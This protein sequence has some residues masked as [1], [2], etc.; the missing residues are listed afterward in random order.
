MDAKSAN[1]K[2]ED[3]S[4]SHEWS[5]YGQPSHGFGKGGIFLWVTGNTPPSN[6]QIYSYMVKKHPKTGQSPE[7]VDYWYAVGIFQAF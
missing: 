5:G 7:E 4:I 2:K 3:N 6:P 1:Q